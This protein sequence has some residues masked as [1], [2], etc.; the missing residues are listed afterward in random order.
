[1]IGDG[2]VDSSNEVDDDDDD[3]NDGSASEDFSPEEEECGKTKWPPLASRERVLVIF[4]GSSMLRRNDCPHRHWCSQLVHTR[5]P[6][7]LV[8]CVLQRFSAGEAD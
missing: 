5:T 7:N 1:M 3:S 8:P 6:L 4:D 2:E